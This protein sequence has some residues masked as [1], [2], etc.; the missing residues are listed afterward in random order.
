MYMLNYT[1]FKYI[2]KL[3]RDFHKSTYELP[4]DFHVA[5]YQLPHENHSRGNLSVAT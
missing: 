2:K 1:K 3:S 5:I 4:R